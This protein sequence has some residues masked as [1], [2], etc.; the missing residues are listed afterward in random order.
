MACISNSELHKR[1]AVESVIK[2]PFTFRNI[3]SLE[4]HKF[5]QW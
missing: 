1:S 3:K 5:I 2:L 4:K